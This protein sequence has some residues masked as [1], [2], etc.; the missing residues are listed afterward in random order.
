MEAIKQYLG[1][2]QTAIEKPALRTL[3]L[4]PELAKVK[5][6]LWALRGL[7]RFKARQLG[8]DF[9]LQD[10]PRNRA[11]NGALSRFVVEVK[12]VVCRHMHEALKTEFGEM[13]ASTCA[14]LSLP[15][16]EY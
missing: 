1:D 11:V 15:L 4:H 2:M 16:D 5:L 12:V 9:Y 14:C 10:H 13:D 6:V 8:D 3:G 7:V